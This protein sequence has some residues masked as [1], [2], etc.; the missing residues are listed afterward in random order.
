MQFA[1]YRSECPE[2]A[3]LPNY[4]PCL[5]F[6][7]PLSLHLRHNLIGL[8]KTLNHL[9]ALLSSADGIFALLEQIVELLRT[10]HLFE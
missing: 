10:I 9:L 3:S 4:A 8:A 5:K 6:I 1:Q 2:E 7:R